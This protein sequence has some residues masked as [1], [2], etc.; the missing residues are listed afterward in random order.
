MAAAAEPFVVMF[1]GTLASSATKNNTVVLCTWLE[2]RTIIKLIC[3][4]KTCSSM[5]NLEFISVA[6]GQ[7][8]AFISYINYRLSG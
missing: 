1:S 7:M 3:G 2:S 6:V 8:K 4:S 5:R